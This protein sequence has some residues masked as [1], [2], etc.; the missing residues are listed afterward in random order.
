MRAIAP[1]VLLMT[2]LLLAAC[3]PATPPPPT[4]LPPTQ[5]LNTAAPTPTPTQPPAPTATV[6][7]PP[8][9]ADIAQTQAAQRT[10]SAPAPLGTPTDPIAEELGALAVLRFAQEQDLA[11]ERIRVV[12]VEAVTWP[13]SALG[14]TAQPPTPEGATAAPGIPGYRI[15]VQVRPAGASA[16]YHTDFIR[17]LK[18]D[19]EQE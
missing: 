5:P 1:A 16:T 15:R 11:P 17:V 18:C 8:S 6:T 7:L 3:A 12:S 2:A 9:A 14:C 19:A 4:T 13:D 10:L